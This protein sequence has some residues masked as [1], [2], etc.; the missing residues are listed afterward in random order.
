MLFNKNKIQKIFKHY[1][2]LFNKNQKLI[3]KEKNL[4]GNQYLGKNK[5]LKNQNL[6]LNQFIFHNKIF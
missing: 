6:N 1:Y 5:Y 2:Q 3:K 4:I